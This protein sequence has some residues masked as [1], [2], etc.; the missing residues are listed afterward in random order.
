MAFVVIAGFGA[1]GG[2]LDDLV[3]W[4][5][6]CL[7]VWSV[8]I[9]MRRVTGG[10]FDFEVLCFYTDGA[11]DVFVEAFGKYFLNFFGTGTG[12]DVP[13]FGFSP[14]DK[15]AHASAHDKRLKPRLF[16]GGEYFA[17]GN[18]NRACSFDHRKLTIQATRDTVR[19]QTELFKKYHEVPREG[20]CRGAWSWVTVCKS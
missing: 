17:D 20:K 11:E 10:L 12:G 19:S 16:E 9:A 13:V 18:G 5:F 7:V 3:V 4:L 1:V 14:E 6:G 2:D 15:I 8:C